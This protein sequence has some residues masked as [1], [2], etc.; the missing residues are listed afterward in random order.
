MRSRII[1]TRFLTKYDGQ[2]GFLERDP[3]FSA[4]LAMQPA[5]AVGDRAGI[6]SREPSVRVRAEHRTRAGNGPSKFGSAAA[7]IRDGLTSTGSN[8]PRLSQ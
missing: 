7:R 6:Y 1:A 2:N 4:L 8:S 5:A 3:L